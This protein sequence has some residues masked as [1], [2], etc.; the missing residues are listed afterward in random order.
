[1]CV[2]T[3]FL[4]VTQWWRH[5]IDCGTHSSVPLNFI[6]LSHL[7]TPQPH[8]SCNERRWWDAWHELDACVILLFSV[9]FLKAETKENSD[10]HPIYCI[11]YSHSQTVAK[12]VSLVPSGR[13]SKSKRREEKH[14]TELYTFQNESFMYINSWKCGFLHPSFY[15]P[16]LPAVQQWQGEVFSVENVAFC[17]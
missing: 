12:K 8:R 5:M 3:F 10:K 1:M 7:N 16:S 17:W 14:L 6:D 15:Y 2:Y 9:L 11:R 4:L 13:E